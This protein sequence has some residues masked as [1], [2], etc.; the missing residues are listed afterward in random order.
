[1]ID[2]MRQVKS[3]NLLSLCH[4][5]SPLATLSEIEIDR[6]KTTSSETCLMNPKI[7]V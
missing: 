2:E 6:F 7:F 4:I 1:M 3:F 5:H